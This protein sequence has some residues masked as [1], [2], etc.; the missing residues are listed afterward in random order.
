PARVSDSADRGIRQP[1]STHGRASTNAVYVYNLACTAKTA[2]IRPALTPGAAKEGNAMSVTTATL[3]S[4]RGLAGGIHEHAENIEQ[5]RSLP[6]PV[7]QGLIDAGVFR[8]LMPRS[9]GGAEID[10]LTICSVIEEV[11]MQDG[12]TGWCA[13]I[14]TCNSHFG[15]LLPT[16]GAREIFADPDVVLAGTFRPDCTAELADGVAQAQRHRTVGSGY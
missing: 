4:V 14:G 2:I 7:V 9:L 16:A 15:G 8:M 6:K 12:A 10:P 3:D 5:E 11:A 13:M 1:Y